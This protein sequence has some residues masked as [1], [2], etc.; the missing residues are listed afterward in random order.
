MAR[1]LERPTGYGIECALKDEERVRKGAAADRRRRYKITVS[2]KQR[3]SSA[4]LMAA[5]VAVGEL[6][7]FSASAEAV[8]ARANEREFYRDN[9]SDDDDDDG[10]DDRR[11][12][13][14]MNRKI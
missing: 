3:I 13:F 11:E 9:S 5:W 1:L 10:D 12:P 14:A 2:C 6:H 4:R 8:T 7:V